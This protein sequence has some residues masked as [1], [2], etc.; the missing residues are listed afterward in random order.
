MV[1][2]DSLPLNH[3]H[4]EV[5]EEQ[6][7]QAKKDEGKKKHKSEVDALASQ[8]Q[9]AATS[10]ASGQLVTLNPNDQTIKGPTLISH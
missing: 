6:E 9:E 2:S 1:L 5:E 10:T 4:Q 3:D 7:P 8:L